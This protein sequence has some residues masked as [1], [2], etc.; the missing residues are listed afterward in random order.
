MYR[1][2]GGHYGDLT[3]GISSSKGGGLT[4]SES[5]KC[6]GESLV[7]PGSVHLVTINLPG[8]MPGTCRLR[9]SK[10]FHGERVQV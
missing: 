4:T 9:A 8:S 10:S 3:C 7:P 2:R 6:N 1:G 5:F